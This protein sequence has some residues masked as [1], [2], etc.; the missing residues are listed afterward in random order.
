MC[1]DRTGHVKVARLC[2]RCSTGNVLRGLLPHF[3]TA[4]W[5]DSGSLLAVRGFHGLFLSG[6]IAKLVSPRA[7]SLP[8]LV[9]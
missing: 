1:I 2:V 9:P 4:V 3:L 5:A 6:G 7:P 8:T